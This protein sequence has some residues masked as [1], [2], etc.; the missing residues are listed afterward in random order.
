VEIMGWKD[1]GSSEPVNLSTGSFCF[2]PHPE[3]LAEREPRRMRHRPC[4]SSPFET[5]PNSGSSRREERNFSPAS[6]T[7]GRS[8]LEVAPLSILQPADIV[9][10]DRLRQTFERELAQR[11]SLDQVL[12]R[13]ENALAHQDLAGFGLGT[14]A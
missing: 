10:V 6:K 13:A 14:Q 3:V 5:P 12:D 8:R 1:G 9:G 2:P 4:R 7:K 11:L